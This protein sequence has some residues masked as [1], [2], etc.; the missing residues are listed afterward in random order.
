MAR[1]T[2]ITVTEF[3][4]NFSRLIHRVAYAGER[5]VLV[6][7]GH[8]VAEVSPP[9]RGLRLGELGRLLADLPHLSPEE[10]AAFSDDLE[11]AR[12]ELA[13][14]RVEDRWES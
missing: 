8:P 3:V 14:M 9:P 2:T 1:S 12:A 5:F 11:A 13:G 7:G 6:K 10:A 4:R